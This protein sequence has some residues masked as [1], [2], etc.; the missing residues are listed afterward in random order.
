M[1]KVLLVNPPQTYF[2]GSSGFSV[3]FPLGLLY[4]H[5][6]IKDICD[7]KILDCLITDFTEK[8]NGGTVTFGTSWG[9]IKSH[10]KRINPDVVGISI[11]FTAQANN[12][13]AIGAMCREINSAITVVYGGP[14]SSV[15]Y[16]QLFET[17]TCDVCVVGEGEKAFRD[18]ILNI[19]NP[20]AWEKIP[21]LVV[22]HNSTLHLCPPECI[23]N[24]DELPLPAYDLLD[25]ESYRKSR[26]LYVN[27]SI[28]HKNSISVITSRGCPY[29]CIFCSIK[30]H[31]GR[32]YRTHSPEY[33]LRH[34][35]LLVGKYGFTAFHFEDDNI[36]LNS[37]RFEAIL[38]GIIE[39]KINIHWD[40][41]NG[42]RAD[43]L[44][45]NLLKKIKLSGCHQL[46]IAIESGNQRVLDEVIR[47][48]SSLEKVLNVVSM[49]KE[50]K[51]RARS[52]YVIG[53]P[54]ETLEEMKETVDMAIDL[55]K[56]YDLLPGMMVA[57]PLYGTD[58]YALCVNEGLIDGNL[59]AEELAT[60]TQVF[61]N[62]MISTDDFTC[63][64][65]KKL[66]SEYRQR[67]KK[68]LI[69]FS[70][71]HPVYASRRFFDK[72]LKVSPLSRQ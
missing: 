71:R 6:M 12:A 31:M 54:G 59:S 56:R 46:T 68:E 48:Q 25:M 43:T 17:G 53:F 63:E 4:I 55:L 7:V 20:D 58:L 69:L 27:R 28:I 22:K 11:P 8:K 33:V 21:G 51:I 66:L 9:S 42:I 41:P 38:D 70:L 15:R 45:R 23:E 49:C 1:K 61:G 3:F 30:L 5:A 40:T 16:A 2:P 19:E 62:P 64:D 14:D 65:I 13:I 50:E 47:K 67:L 26:Y 10:I 34:L 39:K 37:K 72:L 52:F 18:L 35:E 60:A 29:N 44:D 24:L 57:T 36:S 32:K